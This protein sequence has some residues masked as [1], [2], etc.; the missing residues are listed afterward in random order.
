MTPLLLHFKTEIRW[1]FVCI[2]DTTKRI[3]F[4]TAQLFETLYEW[5]NLWEEIQQLQPCGQQ[6]TQLKTGDQPLAVVGLLQK[7]WGLL[8]LPG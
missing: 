1:I 4:S 5:Y 2:G 6:H 7:T 8:L 3:Y